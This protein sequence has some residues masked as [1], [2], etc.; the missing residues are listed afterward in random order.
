MNKASFKYSFRSVI[1]HIFYCVGFRSK[2][3]LKRHKLFKRH[4]YHAKGEDKLN[5]WLDVI[6]MIKRLQA[7]E[8]GY[9]AVFNK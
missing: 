1:E 9:A 4:Y 7:F 6:H 3:K 8:I 5:E 2:N